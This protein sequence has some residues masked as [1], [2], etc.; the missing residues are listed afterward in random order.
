MTSP[1]TFQIISDVHLECSVKSIRDMI[2]VKADVLCLLGD[3]GS[4]FQKSYVD[5]LEECSG[6]FKYVL[7]LS[8]NHE[9]YNTDGHS[10]S[11]IDEGIEGICASFSNVTYLNNKCVTIGDVQF[12][13]STLWSRLPEDIKYEVAAMYNDYNYIY[14][15]YGV[16]LHPD[17]TNDMFTSNLAFLEAS[18]KDGGVKG[19]KN[20]VLTHHTPSF[21]FTAPKQVD[22]LF[23][24]G[25]STEL[26]HAFSGDLIRYWA[27]GH[28]HVNFDDVAFNG[29]TMICNQFGRKVTSLSRFSKNK[30]YIL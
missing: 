23:R 13:G 16:K 10:I 26:T 20:V 17:K 6:A 22:S 30:Y 11:I 18:I 12:I 14:T 15:S 4:P 24:F 3:I 2:E 29:T 27:C 1:V 8:G 19:L 25:L 21:Q 7:V 9:Y 28:T 5:F